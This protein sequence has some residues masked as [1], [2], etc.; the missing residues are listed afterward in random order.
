MSLVLLSSTKYRIPVAEASREIPSRDVEAP[1]TT[2]LSSTIAR[3]SHRAHVAPFVALE[4]R[5][6]YL[7]SDGRRAAQTLSSSHPSLAFDG[8]VGASLRKRVAIVRL[9]L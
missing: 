7:L 9:L 1:Q 2:L 4:L 3:F 5:N 8:L 6:L